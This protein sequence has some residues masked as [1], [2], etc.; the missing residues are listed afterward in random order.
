MSPGAQLGVQTQNMNT[1][2]YSNGYIQGENNYKLGMI[3]LAGLIVPVLFFFVAS[4]QNETHPITLIIAGVY[5]QYVGIL[6]FLSYFYEEKCF[7]FRLVYETNGL[8]TRFATH[9]DV[10]WTCVCG[11][12]NSINKSKEIQ[13]CTTCQTNRDFALQN[14]TEK[15]MRTKLA[16]MKK[17][18]Q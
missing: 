16:K 7:L 15:G 4:T 3:L 14:W 18:E 11:T 13:S 10:Y 6:N 5:F 1:Q 9:D 12:K 2:S 17:T 8:A